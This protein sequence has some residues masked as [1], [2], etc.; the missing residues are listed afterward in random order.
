MTKSA[1]IHV[2]IDPDTKIRTEELF[3]SF[4][5]TMSDA[6]IMFLRK[7]L[8]VGGLPF[9]VVHPRYNAETEAAVLET[10]KILAEQLPTKVFTSL[11][12]FYADIEAEN[13]EI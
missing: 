8:M 10:K 4:G 11:D 6:I 3:S 2:R 13:D 1:N 9:D 12:E 7:S 5:I